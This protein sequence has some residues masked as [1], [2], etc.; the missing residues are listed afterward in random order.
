MDDVP[1]KAGV[2]TPKVAPLKAADAVYGNDTFRSYN[3]KNNNKLEDSNI[4]HDIKK[5][6]AR[7]KPQT[8]LNISNPDNSVDLSSVREMEQKDNEFRSAPALNIAFPVHMPSDTCSKGSVSTAKSANRNVT[9]VESDVSTPYSIS[10]PSVSSQTNTS[11]RGS[12]SRNLEQVED[13]LSTPV[14]IR[15]TSSIYNPG[16]SLKKVKSFYNQRK[17]KGIIKVSP[18]AVTGLSRRVQSLPVKRV[19]NLRRDS[20][21]NAI[22]D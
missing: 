6:K 17:D 7:W 21:K 8:H 12:S 14:P 18:N 15:A 1:R 10:T 19:S 2:F 4:R 13:E 5:P 16:R 3:A 11:T 9:T 20:S 22:R